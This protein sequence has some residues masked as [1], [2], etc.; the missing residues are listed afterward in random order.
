MAYGSL[1]ISFFFLSE[2][3]KLSGARP[4]EEMEGVNL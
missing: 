2:H 3:R 1:F 4:L